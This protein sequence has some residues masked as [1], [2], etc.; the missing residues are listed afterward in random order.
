MYSYEWD[1][2][3]HGYKLT[4]K[5]GRFV[6]NEIR[7]VFSEEL[8]LTGLAK[9][10]I[11]NRKET[12]PL[13]WA[14][15]NVYII[16]DADEKGKGV[17]KRVAQLNG[18]RYGTPL[19]PEFF[20]EG[21]LRLEPVD[22]AAMVAANTGTM[23]IIV[24]DAKRRTK[25]LYDSDIGRC[26]IAYIAFSGG[27][28][29]VAL[30]DICHRVLPL[31]VPVI[32]SD[33]DMELPDTYNVWEEIQSRYLDREF[34]CARA[35]NP[36]LEN[37]RKFSP[38][39]RT[40]R[41]CCSVHKSTPAIALLK[42]KLGR[43]TIMAMAFVGVRSDE[44]YSRSFYEDATDGAKNA[45]QL[46]RMP[47]L[48]WGA[49]ELWLYIFANDLVL[50][51]A[52]RKGLTRVGCMMCPEASERYLWFVD[53]SYPNCLKPYNDVLIETS[54]KKFKSSAEKIEFIGS[55]NWQARKSGV[56]L[57]ETL[58]LPDEDHNGLSVVFHGRHLSKKLFNEWLKTLGTVLKERGTKHRRLKLPGTLGDGIPFSYVEPNDGQSVVAFEFRDVGEK[59]A[60]IPLIRAV[61]KKTS[62]CV[63]CGSCEVECSTGALSIRNGILKIDEAKCTRCRK[64]YDIDNSCWRFMSMR[65]P[66]KSQS[67]VVSINNYYN[68]GLR[69]YDKENWVS[70]LVD[71]GDKFFPWHSRHPL[72]EPKVKSARNWFIQAS[73]IYAK[74]RQATPVV[75][76]FRREGGLSPLGWE[77]IWAALAN[78]ADIIRWFIT[79]TDLDKP[80]LMENLS[81]MLGNSNQRLGKSTVEGGLAALRDM[82]TK[83]PLGGEQAVTKLEM[84]G[85][86]VKSIT[87]KAKDVDPLTILYG[88]YI[89]AARAERGSFTVRELLTADGDSTF[90]SPLV[91]FGI[92]PETFKKQCQGL[93]SRYGI[94]Y[95]DTTFT[96]G[97][98]ELT[99][100]PSNYSC[101]DIVTLAFGE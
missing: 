35:E 73:L 50:N 41:W 22:V 91:A 79:A 47:I 40:I 39:S 26:D 29:S 28:D 10:F 62:A 88:L 11:Y 83:S 13:L 78:N 60:I 33:T 94:K 43:P 9:R 69:E 42:E 36:A 19:S 72:G 67:P 57:R 12:R 70:T 100:F 58:T 17:G 89:I 25:E 49:H 2:N 86:Q 98:D 27:K 14:Q 31:S 8:V 85:K 61:M 1:K 30:L 65:T 6:A 80:Y 87:R 84:R 34:L 63:A 54:N 97:N 95:I 20:F 3:T 75:E 24:A 46:N 45:S 101:E 77:F 15:K 48:D 16:A 23:D 5:T 71:L 68:F 44:S 52:Y 51:D 96:H 7:P 4:V 21:R 53:K 90:V 76:I 81:E 18:T 66:E 55:L 38:P 59:M 93:K 56:V 92:A 64:C 37:W 82:L 74:T 99:V 32:F